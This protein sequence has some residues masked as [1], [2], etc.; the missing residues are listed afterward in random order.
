MCT[1]VAVSA[2]QE[3]KKIF[4]SSQTWVVSYAC[5]FHPLVRSDLFHNLLDSGTR[6]YFFGSSHRWMSPLGQMKHRW[7]RSSGLHS[8]TSHKM[9][10]LRIRSVCC[11]ASCKANYFRVDILYLWVHYREREEVER[12]RWCVHMHTI[13]YCIYLHVPTHP[14]KAEAIGYRTSHTTNLL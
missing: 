6:F 1:M 11:L 12:K 7:I 13:L 9:L 3:N 5:T 2:S 8:V 4:S 10:L 14:Y